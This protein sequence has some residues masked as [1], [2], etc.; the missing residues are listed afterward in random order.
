MSVQVELT[1]NAYI[2]SLILCSFTNKSKVWRI[3]MSLSGVRGLRIVRSVYQMLW[4]EGKCGNIF[5]S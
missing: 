5:C 3:K 1:Q 2:T 4:P